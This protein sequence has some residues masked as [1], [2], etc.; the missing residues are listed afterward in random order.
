[1][2]KERRFSKADKVREGVV[3]LKVIKGVGERASVVKDES[4]I[5]RQPYEGLASRIRLSS[6]SGLLRRNRF[7]FPSHSH[8]HSFGPS[9]PILGLMIGCHGSD[10]VRTTTA[11]GMPRMI[12]RSL[13][14]MFVSV[15]ESGLGACAPTEDSLYDLLEDSLELFSCSTFN[16]LPCGGGSPCPY[17]WTRLAIFFRYLPIATRDLITKGFV[18][19]KGVVRGAGFLPRFSAAC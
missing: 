13:E 6:Q 2:R 12:A 10:V 11:C 7:S 18:F 16:D 5:A 19:G 15:V 8:T 3:T 1:M 17:P 9:L 14:G 4:V